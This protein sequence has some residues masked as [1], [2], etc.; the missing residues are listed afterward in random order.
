MVRFHRRAAPGLGVQRWAVGEEGNE[1]VHVRAAT[2]GLHQVVAKNRGPEQGAYRSIE[3]E[4]K[5]TSQRKIFAEAHRY[6]TILTCR[7]MAAS[8]ASQ[9][10]HARR[11]ATHCADRK[12]N[13][14]DHV[15]CLRSR[16]GPSPCFGR[17]SDHRRDPGRCPRSRCD[18]WYH[19]LWSA[20]LAVSALRVSAFVG[21]VFVWLARFAHRF[22][23]G[24]QHSC[25][26]W[27]LI[28]AGIGTACG[29]TLPFNPR[30]QAGRLRMS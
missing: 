27:R 28:I 11:V 20:A 30:R 5:Q 9:R 21:L 12:G 3:S 10:M 24:L 18:L 19:H 7:I 13:I 16:L 4:G 14:R 29:L 17:P 26:I 1:E 25:K 23:R 15:T 6:A 8:P 22:C 2:L